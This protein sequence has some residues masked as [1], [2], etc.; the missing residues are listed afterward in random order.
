M[1][2]FGLAAALSA[3]ALIGLAA[4]SQGKVV[5]AGENGEKI[6][7]SGQGGYTL[8]VVGGEAEQVYIVTAPDGRVA[9]SKVAGGVSTV[10]GAG[11]AQ[12]MVASQ[13]AAMGPDPVEGGDDVHIAVPGFSLK[14]NEGE[15]GD[16]SR[17]TMRAAGFD[18]DVNAD[19]TNGA[20]RAVVR[21]G[22]ANEKSAREFIDGA[23]GLS[24]ETRAQMREKL[25]L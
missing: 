19:D 12:N 20:E 13:Q 8:Q 15:S 23:E 16:R 1:V 24:D 17:V 6:T 2:R 4:C 18:L 25:G 11:E 10:L 14:V 9:A 5:V 7:V 21:I 22:G 3:L